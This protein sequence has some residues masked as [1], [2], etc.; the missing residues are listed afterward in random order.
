ML[1]LTNRGNKMSTCLSV[2]LQS[3]KLLSLA[4]R[5]TSA[6]VLS[7]ACQYKIPEHCQNKLLPTHWPLRKTNRPML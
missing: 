1:M 2:P 4:W 5:E 7:A 6:G 3:C